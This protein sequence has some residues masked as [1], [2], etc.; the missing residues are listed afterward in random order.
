MGLDGPGMGCG[1]L[2]MGPAGPSMGCSG[3][4]T[5]KRRSNMPRHRKGRTARKH[6][7][8]AHNTQHQDSG[9]NCDTEDPRANGH[10][11]QPIDQPTK[12]EV[13]RTQQ[14]LPAAKNRG[15]P[16]KIGQGACTSETNG[17]EDKQ[18][19]ADARKH[20]TTRQDPTAGTGRTGN[21]SAHQQAAWLANE[22]DSGGTR[23]GQALSVGPQGQKDLGQYRR[24]R[25]G[26]SRKS[27][28]GTW[29]HQ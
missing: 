29:K 9:S 23:T 8:R 18:C 22:R 6:T 21:K 3:R 5:G 10:S 15:V 12:T 19:T 11:A 27:M 20:N 24:T 7:I 25:H 14:P 28:H 13:S 1:G 2:G 26:K 16:T 4:N 17:S